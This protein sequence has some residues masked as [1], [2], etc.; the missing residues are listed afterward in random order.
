M[1]YCLGKLLGH[2][3]VPGKV[4][5][6]GG[7]CQIAQTYQCLVS[8]GSDIRNNLTVS[9]GLD[10]LVAKYATLNTALLEVICADIDL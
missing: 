2:F 7:E 4:Y 3:E 5:A 9:D 6:Q 1:R 10:M 8:K